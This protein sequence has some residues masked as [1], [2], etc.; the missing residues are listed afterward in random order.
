MKDIVKKIK[1]YIVSVVGPQIIYSSKR[2]LGQQGFDEAKLMYEIFNLAKIK[3]TM[4]DVGAH[5][6]SSLSL[7][8]AS[9]WD[10]IAFEP[11]LV[12]RD[13]LRKAHGY[14][15]NLI[16]DNRA[17]SNESDKGIP[18]YASN[19]STGISGLS[20]FDPSHY[21][22]QTVDVTTLKEALDSYHVKNID[23]LKIDTE[24]Y[25]LFVLQGMD[26]GCIKPLA[27]VCEFEN[28]KTEPLGYGLSDLCSYLS[29]R[30]YQLFISEWE[31]ITQYGSTHK[32]KRFTDQFDSL[33][34]YSWGNIIA[35]HKNF[36]L[37]DSMSIEGLNGLKNR[38][39]G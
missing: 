38:L 28:R 7:F 11:D 1:S 36:A 14:R 21:Q 31:P 3:G 19:V 6:G 33:D 34:Q 27:I 39:F 10:V 26:W 12:N 24:G 25:D 23:F 37:T 17:V 22:Q 9:G 20:Q 35:F 13:Y 30:K 5:H 18:F 4:V 8:V 16:I 15:Q 29:T 2:F 32:W